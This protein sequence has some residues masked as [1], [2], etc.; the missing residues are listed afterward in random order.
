MVKNH[1]ESESLEAVE[2]ALSRTEQ[3]IEDNQKS[4]TIIVLAIIIIVGG[5]LAY[6]RFYVKPLEQEA[7]SQMFVAEQYFAKDSFEIALNGRTGEY[8]GFIK[9]A[10]D[11]S[12]TKGGNLANYYAGICFLRTGKYEKAIEYLQDFESDDKMLAPIANGAIGDAY[13]EMGKDKEAIDAYEKAIQISE[14]DFTTPIF[15]L[16]VGQVYEKVNQPKEALEAY[17]RIEKEFPKSRE[18]QKAEKYKIRIEL[19]K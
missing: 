12:I 14:N 8:P 10:D 3:Y 15:L 16:K 6:Q 1:N 9:I 18:V 4:L 19:K 5:Y 7:L 17:E 2:N 11:Y 13:L